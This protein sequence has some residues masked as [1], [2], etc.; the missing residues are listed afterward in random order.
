LIPSV[1]LIWALVT[2]A[3]LLEASS[4]RNGQQALSFWRAPLILVTKLENIPHHDNLTRS[5]PTP[6]RS[7]TPWMPCVWGSTLP[8]A[9]LTQPGE[10]AVCVCVCMC[11]CARACVRGQISSWWLVRVCECGSPSSAM[12]GPWL[13][14]TSGTSHPGPRGLGRGELRTRSVSQLGKARR[15]QTCT[16]APGLPLTLPTSVPIM[17]G[18]CPRGH[19][20]I[21]L[22]PLPLAAPLPTPQVQQPQALQPGAG[23]GSP[24]LLHAPRVQRTLRGRRVARL[25]WMTSVAPEPTL[26]RL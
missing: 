9:S 22:A 8:T 19:A 4:P 2:T 23:A 20:S 6:Q 18:S 15:G 12:Q 26:G 16:P 25:T 21:S 17:Q 1:P 3:C 11:V 14:S 13:H 24:H 5:D 10:L 7:P